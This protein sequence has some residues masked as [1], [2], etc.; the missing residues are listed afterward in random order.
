MCD[1]CQVLCYIEDEFDLS[2]F[3]LLLGVLIIINIHDILED[4]DI[5]SYQS[6]LYLCFHIYV[7]RVQ[8]TLFFT[9][10]HIWKIY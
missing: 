5:N 8:H 10:Q 9:V 3:P 6:K 1:T 7:I 2:S 4:K